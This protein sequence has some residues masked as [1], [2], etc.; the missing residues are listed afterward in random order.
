MEPVAEGDVGP[1][2]DV[3]ASA[4]HSDKSRNGRGKDKSSRFGAYIGGYPRENTGKA[5]ERLSCISQ[6]SG[7]TPAAFLRRALKCEAWPEQK[8]GV[9][10]EEPTLP[11]NK[12][13]PTVVGWS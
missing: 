8:D 4:R 9:K 11:P 1:F 10:A 6:R 2:N 12:S 3:Q 7:V 13:F 5:K